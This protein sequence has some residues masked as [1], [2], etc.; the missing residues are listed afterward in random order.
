MASVLA[1]GW[2]TVNATF[3]SA[4]PATLWDASVENQ[5]LS[6]ITIENTDATNWLFVKAADM[7]NGPYSVALP[8]KNA[9]I[10]RGPPGANNITKVVGF[11]TTPSAAATASILAA[12]S[13][14]KVA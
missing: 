3:S 5:K 7:P 8:G 1:N 6:V 9:T 2:G 13:L 14:I 11:G 4:T 10:S 12:I